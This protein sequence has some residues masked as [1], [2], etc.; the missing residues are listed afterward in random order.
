MFISL[1][2]NLSTSSVALFDGEHFQASWKSSASFDR[3]YIRI[4]IEFP[5]CFEPWSWSTLMLWAWRSTVCY[6]DSPGPTT[7]APIGSAAFF[8]SPV[9]NLNFPNKIP[10]LSRQT[11]FL[12]VRL[13]QFLA[14]F[15]FKTIHFRSPTFCLEF[16]K[17][18]LNLFPL[19][20]AK[21]RVTSLWG[22]HHSVVSLM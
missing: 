11:S 5:V 10:F 3:G 6:P 16:T 17:L 21:P 8:S 7:E 13:S 18:S 12:S 14:I 19:K 20:W 22:L 4:V 9:S 1:G 15:F 2:F